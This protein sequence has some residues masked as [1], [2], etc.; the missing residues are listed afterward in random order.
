MLPRRLATRGTKLAQGL[1]G[2]RRCLEALVEFC[3]VEVKY[4]GVLATDRVL[5]ARAPLGEPPVEL[6]GK[7]ALGVAA[8]LDHRARFRLAPKQDRTQRGRAGR[9][10]AAVMQEIAP[11]TPHV[12]I[13]DVLGQQMLEALP[14]AIETE[15]KVTAHGAMIVRP[16]VLALDVVIVPDEGLELLSACVC[17][18]RHANTL[19][20]AGSPSI[21]SDPVLTTAFHAPPA[22][23]YSDGPRDV[24]CVG[25]AAV[26][27][28]THLL[29]RLRRMQPPPGAAARVVA[30]PS[31]GDE[32]SRE[33]SG[34]FGEL[35]EI[36][37]R[38]TAL[39][40]S[41]RSDAAEMEA[42]AVRER[43]RILADAE[44]EGRRVAA[45]VMAARRAKCEQ[46]ATT[47]LAEAAREAE[48]VVARG[49]EQ[50]P[51]FVAEVME[52][53]LAGGQ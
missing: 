20:P 32:L 22:R 37:R 8:N 40:T 45:E 43:H 42:A 12:L 11:S 41:A 4:G 46:R 13:G 34:L 2:G 10:A 3:S 24:G 50:T 30:V 17:G 5:A 25:L 53:L 6:D 27:P 49:R 18:N 48:R 16:F 7:L 14:V 1:E 35:D 39:L 33:V 26:P 31:P 44:A 9:F 23:A 36:E 51:A 28:L 19:A 21:G 38:A 15:L 29:E 47:M 52:R